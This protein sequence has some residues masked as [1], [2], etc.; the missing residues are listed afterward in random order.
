MSENIWHPWKMTT[1]GLLLVGAT[2]LVTTLVMGYRNNPQEAPMP[3]A[4]I[5][6][7]GSVLKASVPSQIDVDTCNAYAQQRAGAV[8]GETEYRAAYRSCMRQ[9]GH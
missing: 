8:G 5:H 4:T 2:V 1:A 7:S 9:K 6:S 3:R